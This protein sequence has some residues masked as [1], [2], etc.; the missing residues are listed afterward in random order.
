MDF[1]PR[2]RDR[3]FRVERR[4]DVVGQASRDERSRHGGLPSLPA[5]RAR[6][7]R[8]VESNDLADPAVDVVHLA[9]PNDLHHPQ[10]KAALAAGKHC[11]CE[12][13]LALTSAE[14]AELVELAERSGLVHC[15]NFNIRFYAQVQE[16]RSRVARGDLGEIR[17]VHGGYLQD[18]LLRESD[19]NWLVWSPLLIGT[20]DDGIAASRRWQSVRSAA[21]IGV[22]LVSG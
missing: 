22:E 3:C 19:W 17:H 9:T 15:T 18:W 16:A 7:D 1:L 10:A 13:P 5:L 4:S 12:K 8:F 14:S 11:V 21:D 6:D 20:M 2:E